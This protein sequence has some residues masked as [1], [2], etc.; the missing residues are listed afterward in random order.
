MATPD[1][2][3]SATS[4]LSE[5][6]RGRHPEVRWA[7][8]AGFRNVAAHGYMQLEWD[9]VAQIIDTDLPVLRQVAVDEL[10][11]PP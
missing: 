11:I 9:E 5:E 6:L 1:P 3:R 8:V 10:A 2:R 4:K 7:S